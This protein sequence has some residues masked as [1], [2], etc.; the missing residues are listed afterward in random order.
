MNPLKNAEAE[1]CAQDIAAVI[2]DKEKRQAI[3]AAFL[4]KHPD[5][6]NWEG[7]SIGQ[8]AVHIARMKAEERA[9]HGAAVETH[10]AVNHP[11]AI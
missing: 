3:F 10:M 1:K 4:A 6:K 5:L 7:Q 8:R 11:D 2:T 9:K